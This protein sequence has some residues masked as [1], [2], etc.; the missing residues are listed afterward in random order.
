MPAG[1]RISTRPTRFEFVLRILILLIDQSLG[2]IAKTS[3]SSG[4][5]GRGIKAKFD[6]KLHQFCLA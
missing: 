2:N 1:S 4:V 5:R 3:H 6:H